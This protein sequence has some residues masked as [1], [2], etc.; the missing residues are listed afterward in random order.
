MSVNAK[1]GHAHDDFIR[2]AERLVG[3]AFAAVVSGLAITAL[4]PE[5]GIAQSPV[6][7]QQYQ[8]FDLGT[9][10]GPQN[11]IYGLTGPLN[12]RGTVAACADTTAAN[13]YADNDNPYITPSPFVSHAVVSRDGVFVD[14][15]ALPGGSNSCTQWINSRGWIVGGSENGAIDPLN[16]ASGGARGAL[17]GRHDPRSGTLA[18]TKAWPVRSIVQGRSPA[19]R[20]TPSL[21]PLRVVLRSG[22]HK[23]MPSCGMEEPCAIWAR[24]ADP[25]ASRST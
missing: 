11:L 6:S 12:S 24:W 5:T 22:Q 9:L 15:G 21:T 17:E 23:C 19:S 20:P 18:E 1:K 14:L 25:T 2:R 8:L 16:A 7:D 3:R 10:G 4:A 13:P